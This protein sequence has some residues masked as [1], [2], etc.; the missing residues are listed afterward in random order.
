MNT[1]MMVMMMLMT[2]RRRTRLMMMTNLWRACGAAH[3]S[4]GTRA[5]MG[6]RSQP[7]NQIF[8]ISA[9]F[10][11]SLLPGSGLLGV[12]LAA[13]SALL[14]AWVEPDSLTGSCRGLVWNEVLKE[15]FLY[16]TEWWVVKVLFLSLRPEAWT[17]WKLN[18]VNP[19]RFTSHQKKLRKLFTF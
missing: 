8:S 10:H 11:S 1:P 9:S 18:F 4:H 16:Q 17:F 6:S 5:V 19:L 3:L 7:N 15:C 13:Q 12:F 2:R 14:V